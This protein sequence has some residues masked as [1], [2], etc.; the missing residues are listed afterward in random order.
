[1]RKKNQLPT[2]DVNNKETNEGKKVT[3]WIDAITAIRKGSERGDF[4]NATDFIPKIQEPIFSFDD[5]TTKRREKVKSNL[6][7][8]LKDKYG[9]SIITEYI[10]RV[11]SNMIYKSN[12]EYK[13]SQY[14][15][16][17]E[18]YCKMIAKE[19]LISKYR[20][21]RYGG[22]MHKVILDTIREY[23]QKLKTIIRNNDRDR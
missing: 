23:E 7:R 3:N 16:T 19:E 12:L 15:G 6:I 11:Q 22:F 13:T 21:Y 5:C 14:P 4:Q 8:T 2:E 20:N 10:N 18:D 1:M 17:F 9:A